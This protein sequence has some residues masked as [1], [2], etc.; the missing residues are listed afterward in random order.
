MSH[1]A[2]FSVFHLSPAWRDELLGM[3]A[4]LSFTFGLFLVITLVDRTRHPTPKVMVED[5]RPVTMPIDLPPPPPRLEPPPPETPDVPLPLAGI[6]IAA[7]DSP[8]SIAVVPPD[9]EKLIPTTSFTMRA[10]MPLNLLAASLK[11]KTSID[12]D[13]QHI[14]QESEIDQHP[15]SVVRTV[16]MI[17]D[18]VSGDAKTLRVGLL[19]LID[20]N[21]KVESVRVVQ[22]SGN[23]RFDEIVSDTVKNEWL[24]TPPLRRGKRVRVLAQQGFRITFS[25]ASNGP[26]NVH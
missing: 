1:V 4:G 20:R 17:P 9:L 15:H 23:A 22:T 2:S 16:P 18:E 13:V 5:L 25:E 21:G 24:F 12:E 11:P 26:F 14:Y 6:E 19:L 10:P 7:A 8:V 3:V